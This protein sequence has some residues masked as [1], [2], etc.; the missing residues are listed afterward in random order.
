[1]WEGLSGSGAIPDVVVAD[2]TVMKLHRVLSKR[3]AG[4]RTNSSP[5][6]AQLHLVR[7]ELERTRNR[8]VSSS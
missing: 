7:S 8:V 4:V 2:A 6:A 3:Y 5:A 1:M